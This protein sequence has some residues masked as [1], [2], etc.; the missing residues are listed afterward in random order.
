ML[1]KI[2]VFKNNIAASIPKAIIKRYPDVN[3]L[4]N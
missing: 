1:E 2:I 3:N 4:Q